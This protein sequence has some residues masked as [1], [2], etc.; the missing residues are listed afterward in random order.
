MPGAVLRVGGSKKGIR[1]FLAKSRIKPTRVYIKGE[2]T[3]PGSDINARH[4]YF[5]VSAS[6]A[7]GANYLRERTH[8]E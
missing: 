5:L 8:G 2:P 7:P 6:N 1:D 4:S 3:S